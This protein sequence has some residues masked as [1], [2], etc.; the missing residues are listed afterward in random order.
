MTDDELCA[1][2][3]SATLAKESFHH[4]E[5]LRVA[6][7][8]LS[9]HPDDAVPRFCDALVRFATAHGVPGKYKRDLTL[10]YLERVRRGM[11]RGRYRDS[12]EFLE[13]NP[14]LFSA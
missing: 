12:D 9:R 13:D 3:D 8:Y 7:L 6:F 14:E 11:A 5:H 10:R 4:R 1:A 2:F